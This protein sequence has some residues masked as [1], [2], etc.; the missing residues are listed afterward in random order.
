MKLITNAVLI[1]LISLLAGCG[2]AH[3]KS[4]PP[5]ATVFK[6]MW[7]NNNISNVLPREKT[8]YWEVHGINCDAVKVRWSDGTES[9]W[10]KVIVLPIPF[11]YIPAFPFPIRFNKNNPEDLANGS[12]PKVII[13]TNTAYIKINSEPK[14][15][16]IYW[17]DKYYGKTPREGS[18]TL[19]KRHYLTEKLRS[20]KITL[21]YPGYKPV[22]SD[23]FLQV[24]RYWKPDPYDCRTGG[25]DYYFNKLFVMKSDPNAPRTQHMHISNR[26]KDSSLDTLNKSLDALIKLRAITPNRLN[27]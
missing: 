7:Q 2:I 1:I 18:W 3:V 19:E 22:K 14:G 21:T 8:P 23:I 15:A 16:N 4:E 10:K 13:K 27:I 17:E 26:Q 20:P 12:G 25:K 9:R 11:M 6:G 5:G 24:E